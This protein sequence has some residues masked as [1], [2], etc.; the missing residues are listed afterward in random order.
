VSD[1]NVFKLIQP[2]TLTDR[3][4]EVLRDGAR[5][6]LTQAVEAEVS[7]FLSATADLKTVDGCRRVV[8]HGH[9][10]ER[11]IMTGIGPVAV[12]HA[13]AWRGDGQ[14]LIAGGHMINKGTTLLSCSIATA[15][16]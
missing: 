14:V 3:L 15:G 10:P 13:V 4:T 8:R 7:E 2:G 16:V 12:R 6:H 9:L 5:L 11:E 1:D